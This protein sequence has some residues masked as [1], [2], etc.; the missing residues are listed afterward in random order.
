MT[1]ERGV[2]TP[3]C[4]RGTVR[5]STRPRPTAHA[6]LPPVQGQAVSERA[7]AAGWAFP[8]FGDPE[9]PSPGKQGSP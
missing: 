7:Y 1:P 6:S 8:A 4:G 9:I 5:L 2:W 3:V